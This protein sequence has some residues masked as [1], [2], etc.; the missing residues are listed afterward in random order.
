MNAQLRMYSESLDP[1]RFD[2]CQSPSKASCFSQD[3]TPQ[4]L[5]HSFRAFRDQALA[6]LSGPINISFPP[7]LYTLSTLDCKF[8]ECASSPASGFYTC[9][10]LHLPN[11]YESFKCQLKLTALR[12]HFLAPKGLTH[13]LRA[14]TAMLSSNFS[15]PGTV[16]SLPAHHPLPRTRALCQPHGSHHHFTR[17]DVP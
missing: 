2:F 13:P 6:V 5:N 14:P 1:W 10:S 17:T 8:L 11:S 4:G 15:T 16:C 3:R 9:G 7:N 12:R